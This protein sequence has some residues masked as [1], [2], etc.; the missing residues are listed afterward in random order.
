MRIT[1]LITISLEFLVCH[2]WVQYIGDRSIVE[3]VPLEIVPV[4]SVK[5]ALQAIWSACRVSLAI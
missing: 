1:G 5:A 3:T 4:K 2:E